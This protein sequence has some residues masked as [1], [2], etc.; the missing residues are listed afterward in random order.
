MPFMHRVELDPEQNVVRYNSRHLARTVEAN[1]ER[2]G[3]MPV[4]FGHQAKQGIVAILRRFHEIIICKPAISD[5]SA[6]MVGV[7]ASPNYPGTSH[8]RS[9]VAK[10]DLNM[11]QQVDPDTLEPLKLFQYSQ[12]DSALKGVISA[13][14]HQYDP[15]TNESFNFTLDLASGAMTVFSLQDQHSTTLATITRRQAPAPSHKIMPSYIHSFWI[16]TNY[17][18]LPESPV[19]YDPVRLLVTGSALTAL[20]WREGPTYLHIIS[21]RPDLGHVATVLV[22]PFF[23]FHTGNAYEQDDKL[24]LDCCAFQD[25]TILYQLHTFGQPEPKRKHPQDQTWPLRQA[26]F[27]HYQRHVIQKSDWR[28]ISSEVLA[29]NIE[30]VRYAQRDALKPYRY[31]WA[32]QLWPAT[33]D[34]PESYSLVK[35]D[36]QSGNLTTYQPPGYACSEPI[37]FPRPG[38]TNADDGIIVALANLQEGRCKLIVLDASIMIELAQA[39][40]GRFCATTFHGSLVDIKYRNISVN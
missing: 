19:Y 10:T 7:T 16:T 36:I 30:F 25:A 28:L 2:T 4:M 27:G 14:H 23:T 11:L 9:L 39:E 5:P 26:S 32:C 21:R 12:W 35:I 22:S 40:L 20:Q 1:I 31:A 3:R 13:A 17:V 6:Q 38:A 33:A 29:R 34:A 8:Q 15:D 18:I 24:V 37:F